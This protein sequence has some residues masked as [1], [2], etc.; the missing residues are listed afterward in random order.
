MAEAG[1][2]TYRFSIEWARIEPKN[3]E[4]D[5]NEIKHYEDVIKTCLS[6]NIEPIVTLHHFTSPK[7][8]IDE[9]G[10]ENPKVVFYFKRYVNKVISSL[11]K[12][13]HYVCTINEANMGIQV[14]RIAERYKKQFVPIYNT[15]PD[16]SKE[17]YSYQA[18]A[19]IKTLLAFSC[20]CYMKSLLINE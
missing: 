8:L 2:N 5:D 16:K 15:S 7:W 12:Y 3:G 13:L 19:S 11:G 18:D 20:E 10:W 1:L 9:G 14:S 6:N 17:S 4:F